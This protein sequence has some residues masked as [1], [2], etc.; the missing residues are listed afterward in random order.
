MNKQKQPFELNFRCS[1]LGGRPVPLVHPLDLQLRKANSREQNN[2]YDALA[3]LDDA[4]D[5][6]ITV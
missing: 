6:S 4:N 2:K 1:V 3:M 5:N